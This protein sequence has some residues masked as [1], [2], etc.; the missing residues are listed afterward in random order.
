M[1]R[2]QPTS[3]TGS[4]PGGGYGRAAVAAR[5]M[6]GRAIEAGGGQVETVAGLET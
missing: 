2:R 5:L 1:A 6:A 3:W 4:P